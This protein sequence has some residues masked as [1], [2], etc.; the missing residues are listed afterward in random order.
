MK[1]E[2][3]LHSSCELYSDSDWCTHACRRSNPNTS[4]CVLVKIRR[5]PSCDTT[6]AITPGCLGEPMHAR[7]RVQAIKFTHRHQVARLRV[8]GRYGFTPRAIDQNLATESRHA[9]I[10]IST[11]HRQQTTGRHDVRLCG[12]RTAISSA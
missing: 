7:C 8:P 9:Q 2:G 12:R 3:R 5:S 10:R 4:S 6:K 11:T 1:I